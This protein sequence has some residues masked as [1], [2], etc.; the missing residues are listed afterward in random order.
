MQWLTDALVAT[1]LGFL[2]GLGTGGGSLLILW[3]TL[4]RDMEPGDARPI[5]LLFFLPGALI[6]TLMHKRQGSIE[7]QRILPAI[8]AGCAA[9]AGASLLGA[10]LDTSVLK[11]LFGGLLIAAGI[12]ELLYK[13]RK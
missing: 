8:I 6:V 12:K 7:Y 1:F 5:V 10:T 9:A 11:K 3:L 4:V 2:S 13:S